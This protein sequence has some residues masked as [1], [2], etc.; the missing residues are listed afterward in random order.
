MRLIM[1]WTSWDWQWFGLLILRNKTCLIGDWYK[2]VRWWLTLLKNKILS[3][4]SGSPMLGCPW[5]VF[6]EASLVGLTRG[7]LLSVSSQGTASPRSGYHLVY[8]LRGLSYCLAGGWQETGFSVVSNSFLF[9]CTQAG[10][11][12]SGED[13]SC[14]CLSHDIIIF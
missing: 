3:T 2:V 12:F 14:Y 5:L 10:V 13:S 7:W 9:F 6:L 8:V 11:C 4:S 1:L